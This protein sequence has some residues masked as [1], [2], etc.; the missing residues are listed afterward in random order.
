[1][2]IEKYVDTISDGSGEEYKVRDTTVW[3]VL[4]GSTKTK[5]T[6]SVLQSVITSAVSSAG[7]LRVMQGSYVG[8]GEDNINKTLSFRN[9]Q[10][11]LVFVYPQ[12]K[13]ESGG[14]MMNPID[15][16]TAT[17]GEYFRTSRV[18]WTNTGS[19]STVSW[20]G[21]NSAEQLNIDGVTYHWTAIG[22]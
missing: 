11:L 20:S 19:S 21:V 22:M 2:A 6:Q 4:T 5:P 15:H 12:K 9:F 8:N 1:M 10:P 17:V 13:D 14:V 16:I 7:M 3:E 18:I